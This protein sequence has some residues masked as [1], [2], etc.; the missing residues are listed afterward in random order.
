MYV[1]VE[2]GLKLGQVHPPF[3]I[4]YIIIR[5]CPDLFVHILLNINL[6]INYL[7]SVS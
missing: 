1:Y 2:C 7:L 4:S 5:L 3:P 6:L